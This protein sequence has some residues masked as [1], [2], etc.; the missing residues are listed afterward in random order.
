MHSR[1]ISLNRNSVQKVSLVLW[2]KLFVLYDKILTDLMD[3]HC[4]IKK[5]MISNKFCPWMDVE[6]RGA[7]E[8]KAGKQ[9]GSG[10]VEKG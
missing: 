10:A 2:M 4:P 8:G 3:K 5:K 9:R 7:S 1:Q 6:L